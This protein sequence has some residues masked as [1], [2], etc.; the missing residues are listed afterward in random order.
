[1]AEKGISLRPH[2]KTAKS[3]DVAR[4]A[5]EGHSG[6]ITVSTLAEARY[7]ALGGFSDILYAVGMVPD[8]AAEVASL[9]NQGTTMTLITDSLA[10]VT[11]LA[12]KA[13]QMKCHFRLMI[14]IDC[15][16]LRGGLDPEA[17]E[18]I[19]L[20]Q[21]IA[22]SPYLT[23]AGVMTHGGHSYG[24]RGL[25]K[26]RDIAVEERLAVTRAAQRLRAAGIP[27]PVVS[28][29]STPTAVAADDFEGL[30]EMR[31]GV[32]M[33]N[34]L[35]Q[36]GIESCQVAD[37][38]LSVICS[39][40][41]H[42]PRSGRI[43]IDAGALALSKDTGGQRFLR[44][45]GY[46]RVCDA[47]GRQ[48][49]G[50]FVSEVHQEHGLVAS[51]SGRPD[52][53]R[54]PIGMKLRILPNHACITAAGYGHYWVTNRR[55]EIEARWDRLNGWWDAPLTGSERVKLSAGS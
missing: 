27:C 5:T 30:T 32:Y 34:D 42:N 28:A 51:A 31:P 3:I 53:D 54:F 46:G 45:V 24:V 39:V 35:D 15:G 8:K 22:Q 6:A 40:I 2:L 16:G 55:G 13:G 20:A 25:E 43:L 12:N 48:F 44:D 10:C 47:R 41:G 11:G 9:Q 18:L 37:L 26:V 50:L 17:P 23:L 49:D 38:A 4:R 19:T 36:V 1:M 14:E 21:A 52:F 7:F 29:G 33:F